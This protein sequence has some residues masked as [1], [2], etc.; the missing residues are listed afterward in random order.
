MNMKPEPIAA[1]VAL[2]EW[3][4]TL[5]LEAIPPDIVA[6]LKVCLLD[7]I[8]CGLF[9]AMQPWG[10]I[11]ADTAIALSGGGHSSLFARSEKASPAD[12][13]LANGTAIH[14]FE[15][16]D[17]HV[18]SSLHPGAV[19]FPASF[20]I[21]EAQGASGERLLT[22]LAAGYEIGLRVGI[23]AGV[24]HSTSGYHVTGTAGALGA[25]AAAARALAISAWD[26]TPM[27]PGSVLRRRRVSMRQGWAR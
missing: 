15:L 10:K 9:G 18:S 24:S 20:A 3:A 27:R 2:A 5:T 8:G 1:T 4:S 19:A 11:V 7:S 25:A 22:A 13:A 6:H 21:A 23:C 16:D 26:N 12:A 17:A 14:G